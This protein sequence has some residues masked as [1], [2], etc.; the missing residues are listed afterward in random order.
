MALNLLMELGASGGGRIDDS[1]PVL[2]FESGGHAI[3][4]LGITED[5]VF[6]C[7]TYLIKNGS[8][9]ILVDP[10]GEA[11][12]AQVYARVSQIMEPADVTGMILCHQDPDVAGSMLEWLAVNRNI[13]V[14]STPRT[15]V[16][17]PHYGR[18]DYV[19]YDVEG[20]DVFSLPDGKKLRFFPSP[21]LHFPG[22]FVTYDEASGLLFS[23][24]IWAALDTDWRLVVDSFEAHI[25]KLD[26]FHKDYMPS[27]KAAR[28]FV[29][30]IA[31]L[32]IHGIL[33]QHGSLIRQGHVA[34]ALTYL[35]HLE[36][37]LDLLYSDD[38]A[39]DDLLHEIPE[40]ADEAAADA[41]EPELAVDE[42]EAGQTLSGKA[43]LLNQALRQSERLAHMRDRA[44]RD[45]KAAERRL[46]ESRARLAEA[47]KIG[48]LGHWEW[49][50]E[51]D[52]LYW[53]DEI[54]RI[55]GLK[56]QAF[57]ATYEAFV[58]MIHPDDR[59]MVQAAVDQ[60]LAADEPYS[61]DHRI[62]RPDGTVRIVHEQGSSSRNSDGKVIGMFGI[63]QDITRRKRT[64]ERLE[65]SNRLIQ[66]VERMQAKF[67]AHDDPFSLYSDLLNDILIL[68]ESDYGFIGEVLD[69][70]DEPPCLKFY[71]MSNLA[72]DVESRAKYDSIRGEGFE[73][74]DMN[75]LI[76][77]AIT[78]GKAVISNDPGTDA[79]RGGMP[80]GHPA[81]DHFAGIPVY[82]GEKIVGEIGLA[83]RAGGYDE[84]LLEYMTPLIA[85]CGRIIVARRDR[86]ARR[87]AERKLEEMARMDGLLQIPNRRTFDD[88]FAQEWRRALRY[89][90]P[91]SLLMIDVDHFKRYNDHYGH[92]AGDEC[93][94]CVARLIQACMRRSTDMVARY[95]GEEF[96]C[97]LPDTTLEGALPI[98]RSIMAAVAAEGMEHAHSPVAPQVTLSIGIASMV[99]ATEA[100]P[101]D[102]LEQA[103]ARLYAAKESGR[104]RIVA[105]AG[106]RLD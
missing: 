105:D 1:K 28:G 54:Y 40:M 65:R 94:I 38:F 31:G 5:T 97:L 70:P 16:L 71:A 55:F 53:S 86:D 90:A 25:P 35:E 56:P 100:V 73:L 68:S 22:A 7:N 34:L 29:H 62:V 20:E 72:W 81:L 10:G 91:L 106:V 57:A 59:Q 36:C 83:N 104:N 11:A 46:Q 75:N 84:A 101:E 42:P 92:H 17:L 15:H 99:P 47:Q 103:D 80:E 78:S 23:G 33:P 77:R 69:A 37:G 41:Q 3:Y 58:G 60:A 63:V 24:D 2:L 39:G 61:I 67:I 74:R 30:S 64:E 89:Q 50:I 51:H 32:D 79:R 9:A 19:A 48:H 66:T 6:R 13:R 44:L 96:V 27:N 85:A 8:E 45:L 4:W 18:T 49:D 76:G 98:A 12:F 95:G 52:V 88:Y 26:L 93:L 87:I 14:L 43:H 82:Y 21:F 102:L